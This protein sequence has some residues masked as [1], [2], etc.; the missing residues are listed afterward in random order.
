VHWFAIWM[1]AIGAT[2]SAFW[3]LV[4]NSWQQTPAGF[5]LVGGRAQ[6]TSFADA[7]FNPSMGVRFW[8][9]LTAAL[10]TGAFF[11]AGVSA[12]LV[13]RNKAVESARRTLLLGLV[14]G[15]VFAVMSAFPT[16]HLHASQVA[17]TQPEKFAAIEGLY[18]SQDRAPLVLF[19]YPVNHPPALKAPVEIPGLLSWLAFGDVSA[20]IKGINEFPP[21]EIPPLW[22]TFVSFH[23]M[24]L[25]GGYFI[26][27]MGF[28]AFRLR[29]GTL[30]SGRRF[31]KLLVWS[32][33]LP[34]I[35]CQLGWIATEVGRQP[36]AVYRLLRTADA[37]SFTVGTGEILFSIILFTMIYGCLGGLYLFLLLRKVKHGPETLE[38]KEVA[39]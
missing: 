26:A 14:A 7:V 9:T 33:P 11:L 1:V 34:L 15:L 37:V 35:A 23:N 12:Y 21:D 29:R 36:W 17:K 13:L 16:G 27:V 4:A 38:G 10:V 31:L 20:P 8:H 39:A 28:A 30:W 24:V 3:I 32:T 5:E 25:L 22:L 6:L 2:L 18:S 19:A